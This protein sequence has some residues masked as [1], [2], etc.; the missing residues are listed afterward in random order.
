MGETYSRSSGQEAS[1]L[2]SPFPLFFSFSVLPCLPSLYFVH[3]S[4]LQAPLPDNLS[5]SDSTKPELGGFDKPQA[6]DHTLSLANS[7]S[8]L[9]EWPGQILL[10]L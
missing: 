6:K 1:T 2:P 10:C 5:I 4:N 9:S 3:K 7:A 8:G